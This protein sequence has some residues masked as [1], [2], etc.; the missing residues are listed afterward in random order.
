MPIPCAISSVSNFRK[1][2][3]G[4]WHTR[5]ESVGVAPGSG[6]R[7][8]TRVE[9]ANCLRDLFGI[10]FPFTAKLPADGKAAGFDNIGDA[11]ALSPI[12]LESY[13]KVARKATDLLL[14][15][16]SVSAITDVFSATQNQAGWGEGMPL[17]TRG[18][19]SVK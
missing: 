5:H 19:V 2:R 12:L 11:L 15:T 16:G 7:R 1:D 4:N 13:L 6:P 8:R 9:Y 18:G 3:A 14:G 17:G 10:E